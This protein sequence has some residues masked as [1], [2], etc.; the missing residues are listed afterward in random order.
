MLPCTSRLL[1][2]P[3]TLPAQQHRACPSMTEHLSS[4]G[5]LCQ[6]QCS[7][8]ATSLQS[9]AAHESSGK[10][11]RSLTRSI[12]AAPLIKPHS[13]ENSAVRNASTS[14]VKNT[15]QHTSKSPFKH[16]AARSMLHAGLSSM[17]HRNAAARSLDKFPKLH[18]RFSP[19]NVQDAAPT[20]E[21]HNADNANHKQL[22]NIPVASPPPP[23]V[24]VVPRT[25]PQ[26]NRTSSSSF[27]PGDDNSKFM[28]CRNLALDPDRFAPLFGDPNSFDGTDDQFMHEVVRRLLLTQSD[29]K[30]AA[31][32]LLSAENSPDC[33]CT[34]PASA[35]EE[36]AISLGL[37]KHCGLSQLQTH[38]E[39]ILLC[40]KGAVRKKSTGLYRVAKSLHSIDVRTLHKSVYFETLVV[41]DGGTGGICVGLCD[42][43]HALNTLVGGS[44]THSVG[45]HSSGRIVQ[46]GGKFFPFGPGSFGAGD[47]VGCVVTPKRSLTHRNSEKSVHLKVSF[48]IND[49]F[50]G[51]TSVQWAAN[52]PLFAA[53]SLCNGRS[54]VAFLCCERDWIIPR[55]A[56]FENRFGAATPFCHTN[57]S[58]KRPDGMRHRHRRRWHRSEWC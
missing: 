41:S 6:Y 3:L 17:D 12:A 51:C 46:E 29:F 15:S 26:S 4:A 44:D 18:F 14:L 52:V 16:S 55:C 27:S 39:L 48:F 31:V 49:S 20:L 37:S 47:R 36:H 57:A 2:L 24:T 43:S 53:V 28:H 45:L 42:Q 19:R 33:G 5:Q 1:S 10:S 23:T 21:P 13:L 40:H 34:S 11:V 30:D 25:N 35:V 50:K 58:G 32:V 56:Q 38:R 54:T 8:N 7:L 9:P 22:N